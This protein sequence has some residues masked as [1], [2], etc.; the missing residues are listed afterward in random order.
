MTKAE[1]GRLVADIETRHPV[2]ALPLLVQLVAALI[3]RLPDDP[4]PRA[5]REHPHK[6]FVPMDVTI[7]S[8]ESA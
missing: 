7:P 6:R 2:H 1:M 8:K 5:L 4:A 3:D